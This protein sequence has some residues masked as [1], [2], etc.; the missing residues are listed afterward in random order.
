[1]RYLTS[2]SFYEFLDDVKAGSWKKA[3]AYDER[4]K[5][6]GKLPFFKEVIRGV[7]HIEQL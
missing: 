5:G 1:V 6:R 2:S 7:F 4:K 3:Q